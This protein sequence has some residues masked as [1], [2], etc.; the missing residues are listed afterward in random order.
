METNDRLVLKGRLLYFSDSDCMVFVGTP[1]SMGVSGVIRQG[2]S[3]DDFP[4]ESAARDLLFDDFRIVPKTAPQLATITE[5]ESD[6]QPVY[7]MSPSRMSRDFLVVPSVAVGDSDAA[8]PQPQPQPPV[9][10]QAPPLPP[11]SS[12]KN[13]DETLDQWV[14]YE[15]SNSILQNTMTPSI[16]SRLKSGQLP[17]LDSFCDVTL[18]FA[19]IVNFTKLSYGKSPEN[20]VQMLNEIFCE[21]DRLADKCGVDK[22][23]TIGDNYHAVAGAALSTSSST[24]TTDNAFAMVEFAIGMMGVM[25]RLNDLLDLGEGVTLTMRVGLHTGDVVG[26][27]IGKKKWQYD[28]WGD[29]VDV[30]SS[31]ESSGIPGQIQVS[32]STF[33]KLKTKY[34]FDER[35]T[36]DGV[37]DYS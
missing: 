17:I 29:D 2:I 19:D 18:L 4:Y 31:M 27:V 35:N 24:R 6:R 23:K 37:C 5:E 33:N 3:V 34:F 11:S 30:A 25:S 28:L 16:S 26:G 22:V 1:R 10:N 9:A 21:F 13:G 32:R 8:Q 20:L 12:S 36:S 15:I 7:R 14:S